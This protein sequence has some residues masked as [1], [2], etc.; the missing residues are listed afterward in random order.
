M[1]PSGAKTPS[2]QPANIPEAVQP[3]ARWWPIIAAIAMLALI[4]ALLPLGTALE[5]GGDEGYELTK[6]LLCSKGYVMYKDMEVAY[7]HAAGAGF[8]L[9]TGLPLHSGHAPGPFRVHHSSG[10]CAGDLGPA[11]AM[12]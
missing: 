12:A 6:G 4:Y 2:A 9:G 1:K 11:E 5:L 7:G 8:E 3:P 10:S